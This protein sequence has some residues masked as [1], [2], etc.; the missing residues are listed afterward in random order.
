MVKQ[1]LIS[2]VK[3][4]LRKVKITFSIGLL[5]EIRLTPD[6]YQHAFRYTIPR[7]APTSVTGRYGY[8]QYKIYVVLDMPW[9]QDIEFEAPFTVI[10]PVNLNDYPILKVNNLFDAIQW[11]RSFYCN[12]SIITATVDDR[13]ANKL[14][15]VSVMLSIASLGYL[16]WNRG[17][18][19]YAGS[20]NQ[21]EIRC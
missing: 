6:T 7:A 17:R 10:Q 18:W 2:F 11:N 3:L 21:F 19:L 4:K 14:F 20:S 1:I 12:I 13:K 8:I 9:Q 15:F 5:D 16:C